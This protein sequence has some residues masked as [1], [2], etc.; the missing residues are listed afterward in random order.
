MRDKTVARNYAE[1]LLELA[2]RNEG[3]EVYGEW[4][5]AVAQVLEANPKLRL[6]L[7]TP[8][9]DAEDKKSA[10]INAL[11]GKA[12]Q[13]FLNFLRITIDKRRQ[14]LLGEIDT[15]YRELLDERMGRIHVQVTVAHPLDEAGVAEVKTELSRLLGKTAVPEINVDPSILG[16]IL[17]RAGDTIFDGSLK[18]RMERLR[19]RLLEADIHGAA[20]GSAAPSE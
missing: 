20:N 11:G 3:A 7:E 19:R 6:F 2:D 12:P 10:L 4:I 16:G 5:G 9:I 15:E 17:V 8:R 13:P 14:R 18:H 1:A